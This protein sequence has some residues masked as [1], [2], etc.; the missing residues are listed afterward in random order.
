MRRPSSG[1]SLRSRSLFAVL[2]MAVSVSVIAD[3]GVAHAAGPWWQISSEQAPSNISPSG[4]GIVTVQFAN[5]GDEPIEGTPSSV[6]IGEHLPAGVSAVS[7]DGAVRN[8]VA[9]KCV[10]STLKCTFE[11]VLNPYEQISVSIRVKVQQASA[12]EA[13]LVDEAMVEGGGAAAPVSRSVP[14]HVSGQPLS[15]GMSS[16]ELF[17]Y[18]ED[19]TPATRAGAHPFQLTTTLVLDQDAS[20]QPVAL[21]RDLSFNLPPGLVG[22]PTAVTQCSMTDFVSLIYETNLCPPSSVVGVAAITANEPKLLHVISRTVPIFNLVPSQGEPARFGIEAVGKVPVVIDATVRTG[23]DYGVVATTPETTETAGLLSAQTTF[24]GVPGDPRHDNARGWECVSG[25][26]FD[27]QIEKT[28]PTSSDLEQKPLLTLPTSCAS[29]PASQP[30][31]STVEGDSWLEPGLEVGG[32]YE[33]LSDSGQLL[34]F[35]G[36]SELPFAPSVSVTPVEHAAATPSGLSV[37]V[38]VPQSGLVQADGT[39]TADIRDTTVTLPAGV[40]LSPSA[41]NGLVGCSEAQAGFEGFDPVSHMQQFSAVEAECPDASKLGVVHVRTPLLEHELEG[42]LYLAEPAPNGEDGKN[43]FG[44]LVAVYLVARD[45]VSGVLVKL[46]GEGSLDEHALRVATTFRDAPEV[47]FED[48]K[49]DLFGGPRASVS[50]PANCGGYQGDG[51]FVPW[52]GTG[53]ALVQSSA[54]DFQVTSGTGGSACPGGT[55]AFSPGFNAFSMNPLAGMFTGFQLELSRPDGDQALSSV[56]I[57]LPQGV[58]ALL[59]SVELCSDVQAAASAC[60]P[61][62]EIGHATAIAG[63]GSEPYV[64]EGGRVFITGP[65]GDAPFGLEVVTPAKAGPFDLGYVTVRSKLYI[66]RYNASV[67]VVSDP[68][69]TQIRGIPLQLKRVLVTIDRPGFEFNPTSC[70]PMSID[71]IIT[72]DQQATAGVSSPFQ[73]GGCQSLPFSPGFTASAVGHGSKAQGTT[74]AVKVTSGG[75]GPNGVLQ[76]GIAKVS[77]QLP[78]QLSSRLPTLQKACLASVFEVNPAS[79]PE[80][81]VIG[82]A[83]IHTPVLRNPLSGPAYLVSHGN[84]AFPD[85]EFILQGENIT[86]VL[87]GKTDIKKGI[88]YSKFE[89]T[90]DAPFTT[91]ETML[92][93]GP[94]G[95]LTP[96]VAESKRFNLCGEK[97]TMPTTIVAQNGKSIEQQTSVAITGCG[98]VKSA[99]VR[100]LTLMQRFERAL[101]S[102]GYKHSETKRVKC[103]LQAHIRYT[104]LALVACRQAHKRAPK[105]RVVC[106]RIVRKRYAPIPARHARGTSQAKRG[107]Q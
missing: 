106:E 24:W 94:H 69:P 21:P 65:Y 34:G 20:Q 50:T 81:S 70:D 11:S 64:Q 1:I 26:Y 16:Y 13:A 86:L 29:A 31:I 76:A 17:P 5:L 92:P 107:R 33:W 45:P 40:E 6:T 12:D 46:A 57:H 80:G 52:S 68:L 41:A 42:A 61:G 55:L 51:V 8:G 30:V 62:S 48:L 35:T 54:D 14:I 87:D 60:P 98:E 77:L 9:T 75:V 71:G 84:A 18:N 38:H 19:G 105:M 104:Q 32:A 28:C 22:N 101:R 73:I 53:P 93:A 36:C 27:I 39:A 99:K 23:R 74:F 103:E 10:L 100:K 25:G 15:F 79:C 90:P 78:K 58:A 63:L 91:F 82:D 3:V 2:A 83:T 95:V 89:S 85:V 59:S 97:L 66:D 47:P 43:P 72:G 44:S 67:T 96:N 56:S 88:T 49:V 102:C 7:I 37:D 4:E